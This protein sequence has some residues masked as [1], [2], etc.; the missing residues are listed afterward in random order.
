MQLRSLGKIRELVTTGHRHRDVGL[1][2]PKITML[3]EVT[4]CRVVPYL[5]W[6][7]GFNTNCVLIPAY[8]TLITATSE[9][10]EAPARQSRDQRDSLRIPPSGKNN[11]ARRPLPCKNSKIISH[12]PCV[13]TVPQ[14]VHTEL[15]IFRWPQNIKIKTQKYIIFPLGLYLHNY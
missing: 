1:Q 13:Q 3:Q 9:T 11:S 4:D 7:T 2:D 8:T 14:R 6:R 10:V 15:L 12:V 5:K